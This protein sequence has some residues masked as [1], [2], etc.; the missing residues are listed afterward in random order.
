MR[1]ELAWCAG[2]GLRCWL[3]RDN[4]Q[5]SRVGPEEA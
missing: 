5:T 2:G 3:Y 4:A 1:L